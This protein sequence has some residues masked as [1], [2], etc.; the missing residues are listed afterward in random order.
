MS[1]DNKLPTMCEIAEYID[2]EVPLQ[3]LEGEPN[4]IDAQLALTVQAFIQTI[5]NELDVTIE[6]AQFTDVDS[7]SIEGDYE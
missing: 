3:Q 2:N 4:F 1:N 6:K 5:N 7:L